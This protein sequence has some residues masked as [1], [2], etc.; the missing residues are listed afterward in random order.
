MRRPAC[1]LDSRPSGGWPD[2]GIFAKTTSRLAPTA[3]KNLVTAEGKSKAGGSLHLGASTNPHREPVGHIAGCHQAPIPAEG[4]TRLTRAWLGRAVPGSGLDGGWRTDISQKHHHPPG[5]QLSSTPAGH[6]PRHR[7]PTHE[8]PT[9]THHVMRRAPLP[10]GPRPARHKILIRH[11]SPTCVRVRAIRLQKTPRAR[12]WHSFLPYLPC[13]G[14]RRPSRQA[15]SGIMC[16]PF[17]CPSSLRLALWGFSQ[18][19][20]TRR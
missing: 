9:L 3:A 17:P 20:F 11:L 1:P 18:D 8:Q 7:P 15:D 5:P 6:G 16:C 14:C 13:P 4:P 10:D 12:S 19:H 2:H